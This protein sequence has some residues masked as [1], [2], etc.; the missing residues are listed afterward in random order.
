MAFQRATAKSFWLRLAIDGPAGSGKT[1][2]AL[3][4]ASYFAKQYNQVPAYIDTERGSATKYAGNFAFDV[5][6]LEPP[7]HPDRFVKSVQEAVAAGYKVLVI[8]SLSHAW[9]GVG[10]LLELV[11]SFARKYSGNSYAAWKDA[12]PIQTRLVD[13][14]TGAN[15]H[16]IAC[17][18]AKMEYAQDRDEKGRLKIEKIGLAP[19]QRE[20]ME[21]EFDVVG[22]M[23][24][25]HSLAVSKTRCIELTD[26]LWN[27]P[28]AD[29]A[30]IL[31]K[32]TQAG[33]QGEMPTSQQ[34]PEPKPESK[35]EPEREPERQADRPMPGLTPSPAQLASQAD[36]A[37]TIGTIQSPAPQPDAKPGHWIDNPTARIRFWTYTR[38]ELGLTTDEVHDALAVARIHDFPGT[39][40]DAKELLI[41]YADAKAETQ[42]GESPATEETRDASQ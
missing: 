31:W 2:T 10:G 15:C 9:N 30:G 25:A 32:W 13:T 12:T 40:Q 19:V 28:G 6:N 36:Y 8:D 27:K 24:V 7:Y 38:T 39:M 41:A 3:Q 22:D 33:G 34:T 16:I 23:N 14:L 1:Y 18:R 42:D 20:G 37:E 5:V 11:D 21:Y 29:F 17:L 4:V 35:P 26:T